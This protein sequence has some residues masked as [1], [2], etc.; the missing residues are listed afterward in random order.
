MN[1]AGLQEIAKAQDDFSMIERLAQ[2]IRRAGLQCASF[3]SFARVGGQ[4]NDGQK[5]FLRFS[6]KL[7]QNSETVRRR[8]H[9]IEQNKVRLKILANL[10][11]SL[12]IS[13]RLEARV[14][15]FN[16]NFLE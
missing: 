15:V 12:R 5:C 6:T 16:Q 13:D 8:H 1:A 4:N 9:Q 14:L 7:F 10:E 3:R 2:K 11:R